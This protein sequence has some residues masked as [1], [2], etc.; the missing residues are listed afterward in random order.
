MSIGWV[1]LGVLVVGALGQ[2]ACFTEAEATQESDTAGTQPPSDDQKQGRFCGGIAGIPCPEGLVCVDDP[3]DDC[4][5]NQ[6]GA[7]CGGICVKPKKKKCK[8]NDPLL[9]YISR[10]PNECA[11]LLF[12]CIEGYTPFFNECGCGC[13]RADT[14]CNYEDPHRRYISMDPEQCATIRFFCDPGTEPFFDDCGCGCQT[15]RTP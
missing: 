12:T 13:A 1:A 7:D 11:A 9:D 15:V 2:V 8:Y 6:G 14:A 10:D 3:S 4:D 5:P